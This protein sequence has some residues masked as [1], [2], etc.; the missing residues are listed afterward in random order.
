MIA[1]VTDDFF[2][3][4]NL[5][6]PVELPPEHEASIESWLDA[7]R[8]G[9]IGFLPRTTSQGLYW[10]AFAPT[11]REQKEL[12]VLLD[13]WV[14]PTFSDLPRSR[15]RLYPA[16]PF[17]APLAAMQVSPLRFE[18]LPRGDRRSRD[19]VRNALLVLSRLVWNRPRS[20]FD[21]P[22]TTVEVLDDLG[23][24]IAAQD[25]PMALGCLRELE[26]TADL[27][28]TNLALLRFRVYE[29]LE[30]WAAIFADQDLEHVLLLRRPI[31]ITRILQRAVYTQY[32]EKADLDGSAAD[33]H[34]A[35][36]EIPPYLRVLATGA[37]TRTRPAV[38]VEFLLG[39]LTQATSATFDRLLGEAALIA[40]ELDARLR[41]L[42]P[43]TSRPESALDP[44]Q[45]PPSATTL[46][47]LLVNAG[48]FSSA[49]EEALAVE[50]DVELAGL[51]LA[52]TRELEEHHLAVRVAEHLSVSGLRDTLARD[53]ALVRSDLAWLDEFLSQQQTLG[54]LGWLAAVEADQALK[55]TQ[56]D[57]NSTAE[58]EILDR[59][60]VAQRLAGMPDEA[61]ARFG[62]YGGA[63]MAAHR[64]LFIE[65][66]G[67]DLCERVLA[68]LALSEKT[69]AGVRVQT[70]TL[71][72]YLAAAG[73]TVEILTSA[74]EWTGLVVGG[75]VSA[76]TASWA[77][78][79]L[80]TATSGPQA[81]A[82]G[83]KH[84]FFFQVLE[85]LR[86]VKSALDLADLE[87]LRLVAD[88]LATSLPADFEI[89]DSEPE[90]AAPYRHLANTT[91]VLYSLTESAITR[92][93][94][95]LRRLVPGIDVRTT[96]EHGGSQQLA[97]WSSNADVFVMVAASAKHAATDFI[98]EHRGS[99]PLIQ[100]NSRG[101]SSILRALAEG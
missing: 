29:G 20:E 49:I 58:W 71:L 66:G 64:A 32:L 27:D 6:N 86:P 101:S 24:A 9:Q 82:L 97:S 19:Q 36:E 63:F 35:A 28:Q 11:I 99:K 26:A 55:I 4:G 7:I 17:D 12:L 98:K 68:G 70:L 77:V 74:L 92:A 40:P 30:D 54:W 15:G 41:S 37:I 62:E 84:Q 96:S 93:A 8:H 21:A 13:A 53:D 16:D 43:P 73:P 23:H 31:G 48:E 18:V 90:L 69:S 83:A 44:E 14:G 59:S 95:L 52:C 57:L 88:E 34:E 79:V 75:A 45:D 100:V 81:L 60:T 33:L 1:V 76:V 22:R 67:A 89:E 42:L 87:G 51:M 39:L 46:V 78:D 85:Q 5:I 91:V 2:E 65:A 25:R 38:V 3:A 56:A 80:Q 61:L 94:Q 72:E 10:Y 50:P 47:H